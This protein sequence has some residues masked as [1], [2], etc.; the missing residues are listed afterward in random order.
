MYAL[1]VALLSKPLS[2]GREV[3]TRTPS[4]L[5]SSSGTPSVAASGTQSRQQQQPK[6]VGKRSSKWTLRFGKSNSN[7][8][9][10]AGGNNA[11]AAATPSTPT[12]PVTSSTTPANLTVSS[13]TVATSS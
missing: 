6:A 11:T 2:A 1:P 3:S 9:A 7:S 10:S 12:S 13:A 8:S 4:Q 5:S